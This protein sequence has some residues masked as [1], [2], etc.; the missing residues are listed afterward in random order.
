LGGDPEIDMGENPTKLG[1]LG[2]KAEA[3]MA[4]EK[5]MANQGDPKHE[6]TDTRHLLNARGIQVILSCKRVREPVASRRDML[7]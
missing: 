1:W 4:V 7:N 3:G 5:K 2:V 6:H